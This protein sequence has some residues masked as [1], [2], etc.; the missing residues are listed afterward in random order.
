[1]HPARAVG[2]GTLGIV[3]NPQDPADLIRG[4]EAALRQPVGIVPAGLD[5]F[6]FRS[7]ER[8]VH[9]HILAPHWEQAA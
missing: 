9:E 3:V 4:I 6:S 7:F 5:M 1:M 8:R 2:N